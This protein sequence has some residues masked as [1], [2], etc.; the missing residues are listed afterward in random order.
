M[1]SSI[2]SRQTHQLPLNENNATYIYKWSVWRVKLFHGI[3]FILLNKPNPN[4]NY[5]TLLEIA[6]ETFYIVMII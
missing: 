5:A 3:T 1:T 2:S 6:V 4:M